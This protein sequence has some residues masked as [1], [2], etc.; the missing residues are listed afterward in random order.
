MKKKIADFLLTVIPLV[1]L[2]WIIVSYAEIM[3]YH[4]TPNYNY[5]EWNFF[6]V[7]FP[8]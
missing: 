2:A 1:I 5:T 8:Y 3:Q 6:K 4:Y 7:F